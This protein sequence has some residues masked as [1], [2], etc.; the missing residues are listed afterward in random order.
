VPLSCLRAAIAIG[1]LI[2]AT[3]AAAVDVPRKV[4]LI[5]GAK[6]EGPGRHDYPNGIRALERLLSSSPDFQA[7]RGLD[8]D[9]HPDGWPHAS[10]FDDAST[11]VWYFDGLDKHPLLAP[12]RLAQFQHSMRA[13]VG[14]V[15]LHQATTVPSADRDF[16]LPR[17]L[18]GARDGMFDRATEMAQ[19][20]PASPAHPVSRGLAPFT[21]LDEFYPTIRWR[22][23]AAAPTPILKAR[24][25]VE[26]REGKDLVIGDPVM[27]TVA[28]AYEREDGGRAVGYTGAHYLAA[29]D[30]PQVRTMLLNAIAWTAHIEVPPGGIRS[31]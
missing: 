17:W 13:G 5:G 12:E 30:Q 15:V 18:G 3:A 4:V 10:A 19:V 21:Y 31:P 20:T 7:V 6:S 25:H 1:A 23:S 11:V 24:L 28:W 14:L 16:D 22:S 27:S 29:F 8:I 2:I 9:A 26:W